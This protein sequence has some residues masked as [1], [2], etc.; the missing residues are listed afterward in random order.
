MVCGLTW[1]DRHPFVG[2]SCL[3]NALL[4]TGQAIDI[5]AARHLKEVL[6]ASDRAVAG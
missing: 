5:H 1:S 4:D 6:G 3:L 2:K